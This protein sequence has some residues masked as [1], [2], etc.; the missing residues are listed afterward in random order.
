MKINIFFAVLIFIGLFG[1]ST[2][3]LE[4]IEKAGSKGFSFDE[5]TF[6]SNWNAWKNNDIQNYSFTMTGELP[7]WNFS[8]AIKM[9]EYKVNI[10]V[11]NGV[12]ASFEYIGDNVPHEIDGISILEPEFTSISDMYQK[13]FDKAKT[14]KE[15]WN[16]YSGNGH[17]ISTKFEIIYSTELNYITFFE[18]VSRW[19]PDV[20]V[21]TTA[22]DVRISNFVVLDE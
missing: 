1:F 5:G 2:C 14:E 13:I 7:Y 21:D 9:Y 17:I 8:R 18:P 6:T 10:I 3:N 19:K 22:H 4:N 20:I 15:W 12:M 11:R 16:G